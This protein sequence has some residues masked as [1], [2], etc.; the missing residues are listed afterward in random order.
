MLASGFSAKA[1]NAG[2]NLQV[3][4]RYHEVMKLRILSDLHIEFYPFVIPAL[5]GDGET[6]LV[7]AGDIGTIT[8]RDELLG[9][10]AGAAAQFRAVCYVLGNHEFY[11]SVW[12][13]SLSVLRTAGLPANV[14]ILNRETVQIDDVT[15]VG[16]TLWSDFLGASP[17]AMT[18][19]DRTINDFHSI[20]VEGMPDIYNRQPRFRPQLAYAEHMKTRRWLR[21]TLGILKNQEKTTV[22]IT[23]HGITDQSVH[24][25]YAGDPTNGAF[26][27]DLSAILKDTAPRLAIHGHV[28]DSFRYLVDG[29]GSTE[30]VVNPRGYTQVNDTQENKSFDPLLTVHI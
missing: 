18:A 15:F 23:H 16:A 14:H 12:P 7:L 1:Q 30:V 3:N 11:G 29:P 25:R 2:L 20:R 24:P 26:V 4:S 19:A 13:V 27:S 28:H 6:V 8:R 22:L 17:T 21:D 10:L 9:F 5:P